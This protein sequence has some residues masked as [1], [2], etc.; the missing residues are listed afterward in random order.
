MND[1]ILTA[2]A[3]I[4]PYDYEA[5]YL[6]ANIEHSTHCTQLIY[7]LIH[8]DKLIEADMEYVFRDYLKAHPEEIDKRNS[9]GWS[10]VEIAAR[11]VDNPG[12]AAGFFATP[13]SP[14][15]SESVAILNSRRLG[16]EVA[17][18]SEVP[19]GTPGYYKALKHLVKEGADLNPMYTKH[20]GALAAVARYSRGKKNS[21]RAMNFLI[22]YGADINH[23]YWYRLSPMHAVVC[24]KGSFE[25]FQ[26]LIDHGVDVN[27]NCKKNETPLIQACFSIDAEDSF[28]MIRMLI[29]CGANPNVEWHR[30]TPLMLTCHNLNVS[31][32]LINYGANVNYQN[33]DGRSILMHIISDSKVKPYFDQIKFFVNEGANVNLSNKYGETALMYAVTLEKCYSNVV[34]FLIQNGASVNQQTLTGLTALMIASSHGHVEAAQILL[35]H[36]A[37]FEIRNKYERTALFFTIFHGASKDGNIKR[38]SS[39]PLVKECVQL[40]IARGATF[41]KPDF[42]KYT[43]LSCMFASNMNLIVEVAEILIINGADI[44]IRNK[45]GNNSLDHALNIKQTMP[46]IFDLMLKYSI[47]N[48]V[49]LASY[50]DFNLLTRSER[51]IFGRNYLQHICTKF[52]R[53]YAFSELKETQGQILYHRDSIRSKLICNRHNINY[54]T[55]LWWSI[56][57][58][59]ILVNFSITNLS[60]FEWKIRDAIS[61]IND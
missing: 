10:P 2:L 20:Y 16:N 46:Q 11:C 17:E 23:G 25:A 28:R 49:D 61:C 43:P 12:E 60:S 24:D 19:L 51:K 33:I 29:K 14:R 50:K 59:D 6:C 15:L 54:D 38:L 52:Y 37:D 5:S 34:T 30:R 3:S 45:H 42:E 41:N 32:F 57:R 18:R 26:F 53:E 9:Y 56:L 58:Q 4:P 1:T 22:K 40:L 48:P 27:A 35:D 36:N 55:Y 44:M 47:V 31:K 21:I 8:L 39:I 7:L 13:P